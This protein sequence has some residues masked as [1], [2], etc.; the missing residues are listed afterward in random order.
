[1]DGIEIRL[2]RNARIPSEFRHSKNVE[3]LRAERNGRPA[4][5]CLR[6]E[7]GEA[8]FGK[9]GIVEVKMPGE[10]GFREVFQKLKVLEIRALQGNLL[11]Q[12]YH[13]CTKCFKNTGEI[14]EERED[15]IVFKCTECEKP[16]TIANV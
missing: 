12:S 6:I 8:R 16:W 10:R 1:M 5:R 9:S 15:G 11:E 2:E 4:V 14:I 3:V 13:L 7:G